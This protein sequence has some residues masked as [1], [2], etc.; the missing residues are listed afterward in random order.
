MLE[1]CTR[2]SRGVSGDDPAAERV[3]RRPRLVTADTGRPGPRPGTFARRRGAFAPDPAATPETEAV[4][5]PTAPRWSAERRRPGCAGRPMPR[6]RGVAPYERDLFQGWRLPALRRP[7]V[8]GRAA[9]QGLGWLRKNERCRPEAG[10]A[11]RR[12]QRDGKA[13]VRVRVLRQRHPWA[14]LFDIVNR[15]RTASR[16]LRVPGRCR[17]CIVRVPDAAQHTQTSLR[18]LRKLDCV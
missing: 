1:G 12:P 9:K 4:P 18:T 3:W 14:G 10:R 11:T 7:S 16:R 2:S 17:A 5:G 6:K 8:R 13:V 15:G